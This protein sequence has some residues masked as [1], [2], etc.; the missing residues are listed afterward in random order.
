[1]FPGDSFGT[2]VDDDYSKNRTYGVMAREEGLKLANEF[3]RR[4]LPHERAVDYDRLIRNKDHLKTLLK[5]EGLYS[6]LYFDFALDLGDVLRNRNDPQTTL[7]FESSSLFDGII[8]LLLRELTKNPVQVF[9]LYKQTRLVIMNSLVEQ[10]QAAC[11]EHGIFPTELSQVI[12][13]LRMATFHLRK[14]D[15]GPYSEF[16]K[17]FDE[18]REYKLYLSGHHKFCFHNWRPKEMRDYA[19]AERFKGFNTGALL[20]GLRGAGKSGVLYYLTAWAHENEWFVLTVPSGTKWTHDLHASHRLKTHNNGLFLQPKLA[21]DW[22]QDFRVSNERNLREFEPDLSLYGGVDMS[23]VHDNE[24][25]AVPRTW[26]ERR[27]VWSDS[28][29]EF[30]FEWE[31]KEM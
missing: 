9:L 10:I 14:A 25:E 20:Y 13:Y 12:H 7:I 22:L 5:E 15:L 11:E 21:R 18:E 1:M 31:V 3:A 26:D 27:K 24:P 6:S 23:G 19:P 4:S 2:L 30:L 16:P 8:G 28:W 17:M 29:K